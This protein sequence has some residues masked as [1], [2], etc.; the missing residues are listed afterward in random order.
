MDAAWLHGWSGVALA[1]CAVQVPMLAGLARGGAKLHKYL[2]SPALAAPLTAVAG[3]GVAVASQWLPGLSAAHGAIQWSL[4]VAVSATLGYVGGQRYVGKAISD[5]AYQR[6]SMVAEQ[7][8]V[9]PRPARKSR[10]AAIKLAGREVRAEDET[11]HFK[12]IGT[13][14]TGKSTAI[15][16]IL[17]SALARGDRAIIAD[18]DGGYAQRFFDQVRGDRLLNPFDAKSM[19]WDLF[20]EIDNAYDVEQLA[21]SF[22]PDH[23]GSDRSWRG[24]ARTFFTA[25]TRQTHDAGIRSV[26]ELYR[27]LVVADT[28]ELRTLLAGTPAQPFLDEHNSRMFDSIRSVTASAV[29]ALEYVAEQKTKEL[30]VREWV[31]SDAPGVLFMP[32]KAG[33]IA[34]LRSTISGWMRLAIFETMHSREESYASASDKKKPLWFVVDELDALG[35]IDGL[36]DALVRLRKF[37]GRCVLGFQSIAQVSSTYGHGDAH[38]IVENCGNTLILRCSASEGGGTA[39]FASQL[40]GDR[41]VLR[42]TVSTSHRPAEFFESKT[43]SEHFSVEPAL[44]PSQIE[45]LPDLAGY[46]KF[47][48][49]PQWQRVTLTPLAVRPKHQERGWNAGKNIGA[50]PVVHRQNARAHQSFDYE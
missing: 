31:R 21:R 1:Y 36:K 40:I 5:R 46:L 50:D 7:S 6:G 32:Y 25:V 2:L 26:A 13:T 18:P 14:G 42:T 22:I 3:I 4:G 39:R 11:K 17:A 47:A 34:A 19:K 28:K 29:S 30:S 43:R 9:T 23:E 48:S 35:Q 37:G 33:Q 41:E 15:Q 16:E 45:Q 27:L 20:G 24:Y 49:E 8:K 12:M 44:M 38:T 10:D